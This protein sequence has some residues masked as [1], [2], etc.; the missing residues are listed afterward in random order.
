MTTA[1]YSVRGKRIFDEFAGLLHFVALQKWMNSTMLRSN[2]SRP[3]FCQSKTKFNFN[4]EKQHTCTKYRQRLYVI[5]LLCRLIELR[6]KIL[7][8]S[9]DFVRIKLSG[10]SLIKTKLI[11]HFS[12]WKST[13]NIHRESSVDVSDTAASHF[14]KLNVRLETYLKTKVGIS[15]EKPFVN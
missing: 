10:L 1:T 7:F 8:Y 15:N 9:P 11:H 4:S 14:Q 12:I 5:S 2:Y 6:L 3:L 13:K